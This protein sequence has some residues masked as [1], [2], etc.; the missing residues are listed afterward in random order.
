VTETARKNEI[1]YENNEF[2]NIWSMSGCNKHVI[3]L[4]EEDSINRA[5]KLGKLRSIYKSKI[6]TSKV[7][8]MVLFIKLRIVYLFT[9]SK[10]I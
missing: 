9:N 7:I 6:I 5:R 1:I 2:H 8:N 4:P 3:D 10:F